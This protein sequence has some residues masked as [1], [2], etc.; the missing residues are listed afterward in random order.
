MEYTLIW[1]DYTICTIMNWF[2]IKTKVEVKTKLVLLGT[3]KNSK[4]C[5]VFMLSCTDLSQRNKAQL[6]FLTRYY[7]LTD[8]IQL[9]S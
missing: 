6:A 5:K 9:G 3:A 1:N 2:Y 4:S 7:K 8:V